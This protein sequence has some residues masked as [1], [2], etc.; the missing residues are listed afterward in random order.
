MTSVT[1]TSSPKAPSPLR[2][3]LPGKKSRLQSA[4]W[5]RGAARAGSL[6]SRLAG[7]EPEALA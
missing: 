5:S 3:A 1:S 4:A 2:N 6:P 7:V